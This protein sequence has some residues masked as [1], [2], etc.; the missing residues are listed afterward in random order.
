MFD[1]VIISSDESRFLEYLPIVSKAWKKYF[2]EVKLTFAYLS[3]DKGTYLKKF[4]DDVLIFEPVD[5]VPT[6]N[7][8]K[9]IRHLAASKYNDEVVMIEDIDTIPLQKNWFLEKTSK[10]EKGTLLRVG[11]EVLED[12]I[13]SDKIPIS[14]MTAEGYVWKEFINPLDLSYEELALSWM[15]PDGRTKDNKQSLGNHPDLF[16]D[17]SLI[18]VLLSNSNVKQTKIRRDVDIKNF[19]IDRSW[20]RIDQDKLFNDQYICCNFLRPFLRHYDFFGPII[21]HIYNYQ[22]T[23]NEYLNL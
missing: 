14:T 18:Q 15:N 12:G 2:P 9:M 16:S 13:F 20:W 10:R 11:S 3:N 6:S 22:L 5:G 4:V 23:K 19:W 17:E 21:K 8:A 7:Q 1:R